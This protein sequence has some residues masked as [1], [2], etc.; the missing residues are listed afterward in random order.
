M[1]AML[2]NPRPDKEAEEVEEAHQEQEWG[3]ESVRKERDRESG[4]KTKEECSW[5][6]KVGGATE[7]KRVI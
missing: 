6:R 3:E 1:R 4:R 7:L 5:G 2:L